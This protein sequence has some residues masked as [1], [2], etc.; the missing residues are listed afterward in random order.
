MLRV[1]DLGSITLCIIYNGYDT[2][3]MIQLLNRPWRNDLA[4]LASTADRSVLIVAPYIKYAEARW[5]CKLLRPGIEVITLANID[6]EAVST[7]ALDLAALRC[8]AE[9]SPSAKLIALSNLHAKVFVADENV[10]IVTS[11]NLTRA[12]LDRNLEYGVLLNE[13]GLVRAV[14]SDMLSFTRLGSQVDT[15]TITA[16]TPLETE[17]RQARSNITSSATPAAKRRFAEVMR[18]AR[19]ALASI[20]VGNRSAHAVFGEALQFILSRGPQ[21]TKAIQQEVRLLM[22]TLCDE[23]EYFMIKG[24]RY[25]KAWKRRL[26]HAQLHLKR[27]GIIT[28]NTSER[29]WA[30]IH[31]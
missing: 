4:A 14:R 22:P 7:S 10:A 17:L 27:K 6:A 23:P 1:Y 16:L 26:R 29:T 30:L 13:T 5:F 15:S 25:G 28:Y 31:S 18:Q 19:P 24:E 9:A 20:Q 8:L 3:G 2:Q 12:A 21:T 11:G